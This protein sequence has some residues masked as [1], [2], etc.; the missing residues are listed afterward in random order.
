M[1]Y[2]QKVGCHRIK[3]A[4]YFDDWGESRRNQ[5]TEKRNSCIG[6]VGTNLEPEEGTPCDC[7]SDS[8]GL[9]QARHSNSQ[10]SS[11]KNIRGIV[12]AEID[13]SYTDHEKAVKEPK[14][15]SAPG[16]KKE[17]SH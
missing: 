13:A 12:I 2:S 5:E 6:Q 1:Q 15:T 17:T 7:G 16:D 10:E 3:I 14:E 4:N 11:A 9:R 8:S